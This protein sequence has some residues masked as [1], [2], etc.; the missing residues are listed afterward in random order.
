M[1]RYEQHV[2]KRDAERLKDRWREYTYLV[3]ARG[4]ISSTKRQV[5]L[6]KAVNLRGRVLCLSV[7]LFLHHMGALQTRATVGHVSHTLA[8]SYDDSVPIKFDSPLSNQTS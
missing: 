5:C 7:R 4:G 1:R 2:R 3:D 8:L 6:K